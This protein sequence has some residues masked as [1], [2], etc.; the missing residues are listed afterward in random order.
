MMIENEAIYGTCIVME[1]KTGKIKAIA[2][3]GRQSDGSYWEDYNYALAAS[4]PGSTWKLT[5]LMAALEEK[6]V[7]NNSTLNLEG[8]RWMVSNRTVYDS[9]IHGLHQATVQ[10]SIL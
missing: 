9:E 10:L 7:T 4:E 8:G 5:T 1:V 2:N 3:L 6:V